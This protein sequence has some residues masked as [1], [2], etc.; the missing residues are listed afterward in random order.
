M[1]VY[2]YLE[3]IVLQKFDL[4]GNLESGTSTREQGRRE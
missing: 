3:I 1:D 4:L 2:K